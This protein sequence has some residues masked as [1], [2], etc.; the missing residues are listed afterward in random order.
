MSAGC[1]CLGASNARACGF[2]CACVLGAQALWVRAFLECRRFPRRS[3]VAGGRANEV[4]SR[5][6]VRERACARVRA[7]V[8]TMRGAHAR[9][10]RPP[11]AQGGILPQA[12]APSA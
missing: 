3:A 8:S 2:A 6:C 10:V 12:C 7:R 4:P 5:A 11:G 1:C 9:R